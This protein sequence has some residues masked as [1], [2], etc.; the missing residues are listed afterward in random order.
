MTQELLKDFIWHRAIEIPGED[1][2][3]TR[4]D[5]A[6][7]I[8]KWD[9]FGLETEYAWTMTPMLPVSKGGSADFMSLIPYHVK[10]AEA[11]GENYPLYE[12]VLTSDGTHNIPFVQKWDMM[13]KL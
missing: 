5:Y 11:K 1:S 4:L 2:E 7:A 8:I 3:K 6:G 13:K 12:T 10:N 9:E